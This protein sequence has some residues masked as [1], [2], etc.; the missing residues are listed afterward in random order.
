MKT[1]KIISLFALLA[2]AVAALAGDENSHWEKAYP[3]AE[4]GFTRHVLHLTT[5]ADEFAA[6]VELIIG[7][8]VETDGVNNVSFSGNIQ[9]KDVEGW[10]YPRYNVTVGPMIS[11]MMAADPSVPKVKKFVVLGGEPYL[12]RY[13]SKLPVVVYAPEGFEVRHRLWKADPETK[14]VPKG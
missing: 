4:A 12:I 7:K 6:K 8:T 13:N 2:I 14:P 3:A 1:F 11:T 5:L 10:G 9:E